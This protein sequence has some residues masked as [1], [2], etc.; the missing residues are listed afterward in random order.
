MFYLSKQRGG[1]RGGDANFSLAS[2]LDFFL[3]PYFKSSFSLLP[4]EKGRK[5]GWYEEKRGNRKKWKSTAT[6]RSCVSVGKTELPTIKFSHEETE[7]LPRRNDMTRWLI[8]MGIGY[9][10]KSSICRRFFIAFSYTIFKR[11]IRVS[12]PHC[13][14]QMLAW[15]HVYGKFC[16]DVMHGNVFILPR[17]VA[18]WTWLNW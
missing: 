1:G 5:N 16:I 13:S 7:N 6:D 4:N 14:I 9:L 3:L 17:C 18:T 11:H 12:Q 10:S 2:R 8:D 15:W